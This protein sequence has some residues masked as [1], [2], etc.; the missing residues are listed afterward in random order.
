MPHTVLLRSAVF[1]SPKLEMVPAEAFLGHYSNPDMLDRLRM[2][3]VL[4]FF[5]INCLSFRFDFD[6][7][8]AQTCDRFEVWHVGVLQA[9][10]FC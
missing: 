3:N 10:D 1:F 9:E 8:I 5:L 4:V 7:T 2:V 6:A